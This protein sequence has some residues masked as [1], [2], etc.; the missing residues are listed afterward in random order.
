VQAALKLQ[1]VE[2][3]FG[4][5]RAVSALDLIV[6]RGETCGLI[7]PSGAGK[8]TSI[9][10]I[11]SIL[12]PD[13]GKVEV[14]GQAS[15]LLAKDRIGYLPEER[16]VYRRMRVGAFLKFLA[17][18]KGMPEDKALPR[19][20][21]L[22]T[23]LGLDDILPKKCE[24]LS[25]GMLQR[26][27]FVGAILHQPELL[28]L[29]EP[30]SGLDP[31]SVR[32]LKGVIAAERRRGTTILF[33]THVMEQAEELCDRVVMIHKGRKVLDEPMNSLRRRY[34]L[35]RVLFEP[36]D[37]KADLD[38]LRG[39][40]GVVSVQQHES[41]A[42]LRLSPGIDPAAVIREAAARVVPA[43]VEIARI[44]LEDVFV[45]IVRGQAGSQESELALRQ[46]LQGLSGEKV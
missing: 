18:L 27:Q 31:V 23:E 38:V 24:D 20:K 3:S 11:M 37:A 8:T 39:V 2:K 1:G 21:E 33:S 40:A 32:A 34:D 28:I 41:E 42:E 10:L 44:R 14:L 25:K 30:F 7:G 6:P 46:H 26:V 43:R 16:G 35:T 45:G 5:Q 29:D 9:R 4:D 19:A 36:L 22:L 12:F 17:G 13:S 15:A